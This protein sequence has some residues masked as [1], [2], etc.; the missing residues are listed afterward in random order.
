MHNYIEFF[1]DLPFWTVAG[2]MLLFGLMQGIGEFLEFKGKIVPE[3]MKIRKF[4]KRKKEEREAIGKMPE[5][6][7]EH[8]QVMKD[9]QLVM[10][11]Y[12]QLV[13]CNKKLTK[14]NIVMSD[15]MVETNRLLK[16]IDKHYSADN[17]AMRD[18]WMK[19]VNEHI[20]ESDKRRKE[21]NQ[22]MNNLAEKLDKNNADTLK[23]LIDNMR[24]EL[25]DFTSK[26]ADIS[27]PLSKEQ[28]Q[29]FYNVHQEYEDIL[30]ENG[31]TNGQVD[32][33]YNVA[34]KS[35]EERLKKHAFIEDN[36]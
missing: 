5:I 21:Q 15:L 12:K 7:K 28:Y 11:D 20:A 2:F 26:A 8:K 22:I 13:E 32:V 31:M 9:I 34:T 36:V 1:E 25:L 27:Y 35:F 4:F 19:E 24:K 16:D 33:A 3:F 6:V 29:R 17:I 23:I 14:D 18:E 30:K 10:T